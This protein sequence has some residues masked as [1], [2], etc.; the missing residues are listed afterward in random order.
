MVSRVAQGRN[1]E[2]DSSCY[3]RTVC[4]DTCCLVKDSTIRLSAHDVAVRSTKSLWVRYLSSCQFPSIPYSEDN[5]Q[6]S[7]GTSRNNKICLNTAPEEYNLASITV[8]ANISFP[9]RDH[10]GNYQATMFKSKL[11]VRNFLNILFI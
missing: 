2:N 1:C 6:I 11:C 8:L 10:H 3:Y 7:T 9:C 4:A 5:H